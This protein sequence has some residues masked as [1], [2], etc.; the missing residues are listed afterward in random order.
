[1]H[2]HFVA[3]NFTTI[4][5]RGCHYQDDGLP[6]NC[7]H[8]KYAVGISTE[9]CLTCSTDGCN[10]AIDYDLLKSSL[11]ANNAIG[12][13]MNRTMKTLLIVCGFFKF[14]HSFILN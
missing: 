10:A 11:L 6:R 12:M 8:S 4:V 13:R 9:Y 14:C 7:M 2:T 3:E 5:Y 1:M